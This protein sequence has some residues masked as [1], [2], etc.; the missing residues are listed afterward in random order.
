[1]SSTNINDVLGSILVTFTFECADYKAVSLD[2]DDTPFP[3]IAVT[4]SLHPDVDSDFNSQDA[5]P[6]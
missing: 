4:S 5:I 3:R 1:M 6:Q 2:E